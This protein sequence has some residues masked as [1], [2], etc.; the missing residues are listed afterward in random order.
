VGKFWGFCE[1]TLF[2]LW[3]FCKCNILAEERC[4]LISSTSYCIG[5]KNPQLLSSLHQFSPPAYILVQSLEHLWWCSACDLAK[6]FSHPSLVIY[7]FPNSPIKWGLLVL[8]IIGRWLITKHID[9]SLWLA[10]QKKGAAVRPYYY[11]FLWQL[12]G[13]AVPSTNLSE[14]SK[15]VGSK[16]FCRAKITYFDFSS[17]VLICRVILSTNGVALST[18]TR[19]HTWNWMLCI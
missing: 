19:M 14:L 7:F 6:C 5:V 4:P 17:V 18:Y 11:T 1:H 12:L 13:F 9:Q 3:Y 10:S 16:P 2:R 15:N 8:Q